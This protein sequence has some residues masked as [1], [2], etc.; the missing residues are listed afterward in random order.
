MPI[1]AQWNKEITQSEAIKESR[2]WALN[3]R[4]FTASVSALNK[5]NID[6]GTLKKSKIGKAINQILKMEI[7]DSNTNEAAKNLVHD[8]KKLVV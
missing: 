8:W 4:I 5:F 6:A 3:R 2:E 7:F 1:I